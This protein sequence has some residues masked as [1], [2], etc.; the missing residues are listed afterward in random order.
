MDL[1][2]I[3][4]KGTSVLDTLLKT[5]KLTTHAFQPKPKNPDILQD[6]E[7]FWRKRYLNLSASHAALNKF[8]TELNQIFDLLICT[9]SPS[10]S[11]ITLIKL[12][13]LKLRCQDIRFKPYIV[14]I[15]KQLKIITYYLF[16]PNNADK[17]MIV[18]SLLSDAN[19]CPDGCYTKLQQIIYYLNNTNDLFNWLANLRLA[20]IND[21]FRKYTD[22]DKYIDLSVHRYNAILI[23]AQEIGLNV[24]DDH[25]TYHQL[26][27]DRYMIPLSKREQ[28]DFKQFF[29]SQ[30]HIQSIID[31][32]TQRL[33]SELNQRLHEFQTETRGLVISTEINID[34]IENKL[35]GLPIEAPSKLFNLED[36]DAFYQ[37]KSTQE[38]KKEVAH[39]LVK[40]NVLKKQTK[41]FR[42]NKE[43]WEFNIVDGDYCGDYGFI[44]RNATL[45]FEE[46]YSL[47]AFEENKLYQYI[48]VEQFHENKA[49]FSLGQNA[50][51]Y[52]YEKKANFSN[53]YLIDIDFQAL[54]D[55][56]IST[57]YDANDEDA[58]FV[59]AKLTY[60]QLMCFYKL[61][62]CHTLSNNYLV[63]ITSAEQF[64]KIITEVI[65]SDKKE[66][67]A[68]LERH[69][70]ILIVNK[71]YLEILQYLK[72]KKTKKEK[73]LINVINKIN[74]FDEYACLFL[75][76]EIPLFVIAFI[77]IGLWEFY[78]LPL[79]Y[80]AIS[81]IF[82][83]I[84]IPI[85]FIML[86]E[87]QGHPDLFHYQ[88][89]L[90]TLRKEEE[91]LL[92]LGQTM[93]KFSHEQEK[94]TP[95]IVED[96]ENQENKATSVIAHSSNPTSIS[97]HLLKSHS[98]PIQEKAKDILL[99]M[100]VSL[101]A[102]CI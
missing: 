39:H 9:V 68:F 19:V 64:F 87:L 73:E 33:Q 61:K 25:A 84:L 71:L 31:Y 86:D 42:F 83:I 82:S 37:L 40:E 47:S 46:K 22:E 99:T 102:R 17:K 36:D 52:F 29:C 32:I 53:S 14:E 59:R 27:K 15:K 95:S 77:L 8:Y 89:K 85:F 41:T 94:E 24:V 45:F 4:K 13:K 100:P 34:D 38:L 91:A 90:D 96:N 88:S 21:F 66:Q 78:Y 93:L 63:N 43:N 28:E 55:D 10:A 16:T 23:Y 62:K 20:I 74:R 1:F 75:N 56:F 18:I 72:D 54:D 76:A 30:Y 79:V 49:F 101:N 35:T 3:I 60:K 12:K 44:L 11:E 7:E 51:N 6:N 97:T 57:L 92:A 70:P 65:A 69:K 81:L 50:F 48:S 58:S 98:N 67:A 26:R 2:F 80:C 5:T